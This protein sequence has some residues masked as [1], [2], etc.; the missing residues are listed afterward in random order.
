MFEPALP[1]REEEIEEQCVGAGQWLVNL[2]AK[3]LLALVPLCVSQVELTEIRSK[4][5]PFK[6]EEDQSRLAFNVLSQYR[7]LLVSL[8]PN[9]KS[10]SGH[11]SGTS[12]PFHFR[13][14]EPGRLYKEVTILPPLFN[15][16]KSINFPRRLIY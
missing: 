7:A 14:R 11:S 6:Y 12:L 1:G 8:L 5:E 13:I 4:L 2:T 3:R 9:L 16:S 15:S 10:L